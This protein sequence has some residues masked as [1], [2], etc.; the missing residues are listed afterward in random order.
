M[1][2]PRGRRPPEAQQFAPAGGHRADAPA[3]AAPGADVQR[4]PCGA[5]AGTHVPG[6]AS[7]A[8]VSA[9]NNKARQLGM[10]HTRYVDPTGLSSGNQS[11]ARDLAILGPPPTSGRCCASTRPPPGYQLAVGGS[12]AALREQQ[13]AGAR[14]Q[15]GHRPAE[16]RLHHEAGQC[17]LMQT[18]GGRPQRDHGVPGFGLQDHAD[19]GRRDREALDPGVRGRG[20]EVQLGVHPARTA[21]PLAPAAG[22]ARVPP[23]RRGACRAPLRAACPTA[24][25]PS[26]D[27]ARTGRSRPP[28][29]PSRAA[30]WSAASPRRR[31]GSATHQLVGSPAKRCSMKAIFGQPGVEQRLA[32][33]DAGGPAC[34]RSTSSPGMRQR[35]EHHQPARALRQRGRAPAAG[36]AGG[37]RRP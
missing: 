7:S 15:L 20:R 12:A 2:T 17:L 31:R 11:S 36:S 13:R 26:P 35:L 8:F 27:P 29:A 24:R 34:R 14:G 25:P 6:R 23:R 19:Q 4:E 5:R 16:D 22:L 1:I 30:R 28:G 32:L 18:R 10:D 37:R 9:M 3:G 33:V 21:T